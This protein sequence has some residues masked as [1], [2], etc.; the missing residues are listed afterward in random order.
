MKCDTL[1]IVHR[2]IGGMVYITA[3]GQGILVLSSLTHAAE[4]IEK[5]VANYSSRPSLLR[6]V[7]VLKIK[8]D[9]SFGLVAY[10]PRW[11]ADR[12]A[13]HQQM[14][15]NV[16][17]LYHPIMIE[18]MDSFLREPHILTRY[19]LVPLPTFRSSQSYYLTT[20]FHCPHVQVG[21]VRRMVT[22]PALLDCLSSPLVLTR[23]S[24]ASHHRGH[25]MSSVRASIRRSL[26]LSWVSQSL[27]CS[28]GPWFSANAYT[29]SGICNLYVKLT[30]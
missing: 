6:D 4:L 2:L 11:K 29:R 21:N 9:W 30:V 15:H 5:R 7:S 19:A 26:F 1:V 27:S 22:A 28:R 13:F 25:S 18:E 3:M 10:G 14:N 20:Y 24:L 8:P 23:S 17:A 12:R 16:V